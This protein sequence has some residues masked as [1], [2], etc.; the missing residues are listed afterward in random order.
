MR[1]KRRGVTPLGLLLPSARSRDL[2]NGVRKEG[3]RLGPSVGASEAAEKS[4]AEQARKRTNDRPTDTAA[5]RPKRPN[6]RTRADEK[7]R[8]RQKGRGFGDGRPARRSAG[9]SG[10]LK[11]NELLAPAPRPPSF[12]TESSSGGSG[13]PLSLSLTCPGPRARCDETRAA[14]QKSHH[15]LHKS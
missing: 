12:S 7:W 2:S 3:L 9:A 1:D 6:Q 15:C 11:R 10:R 13:I 4:R 8:Q 5:R 14:R